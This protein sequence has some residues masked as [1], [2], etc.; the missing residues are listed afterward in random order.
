MAHERQAIELRN[1]AASAEGDGT[2]VTSLCPGAPTAAPVPPSR[3]GRQRVTLTDA[4]PWLLAASLA[5]T[6]TVCV[7]AF[8]LLVFQL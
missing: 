5:T 6:L 4:V 3:R 7:P 1:P 2:V 8:S